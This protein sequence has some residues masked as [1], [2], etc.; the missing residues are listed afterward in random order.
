QGETV[1]NR[2]DELRKEILGVEETIK[3]TGGR[4]G[5]VEVKTSTLE[6]KRKEF[7]AKLASADK[8]LAD[9]KGRFEDAR[10][11]AARIEEDLTKFT[12]DAEALKVNRDER[13]KAVMEATPQQISSRM[14]E[15][16]NRRAAFAEELSCLRSKLEAMAT[17]TTFLDE[18]RMGLD[19]RSG[20][21]GA[22]RM[23]EA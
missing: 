11:T 19:L 8:D 21:S 15:L 2:L 14:K 7:A 5:A 4:S 3:D 12:N 9:R 17:Q 10:K 20:S 1:A 18:R 16:M 6:A 13:K 22:Q 23:G